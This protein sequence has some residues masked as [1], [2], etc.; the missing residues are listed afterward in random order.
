MKNQKASYPLGSPLARI[1]GFICAIAYFASPAIAQQPDGQT[2]S[3]KNY[4]PSAVSEL[5]PLQ[6]T[7]PAL[8]PQPQ[9]A[10][11][12]LPPVPK[13]FVTPSQF[14]PRAKTD[15]SIQSLQ[16]IFSRTENGQV[17]SRKINRSKIV[18]SNSQPPTARNAHLN[19]LEPIKPANVVLSDSPQ[20]TFRDQAHLDAKTETVATKNPNNRLTPLISIPNVAADVSAEPTKVQPPQARVARAMPAMKPAAV[21]R[22]LPQ[23]NIAKPRLADPNLYLADPRRNSASNGGWANL[24]DQENDSLA[25]DLESNSDIESKEDI[26]SKSRSIQKRLANDQQDQDSLLLALPT[27]N[28]HDPIPRNSMQRATYNRNVADPNLTFAANAYVGSEFR[29]GYQPVTKTWQSPNMVHRPLYFQEENLERYGNGR[30]SLQPIYS[31]VHFFS[32]VAFLPYK[33]GA[34]SPT[35]CVY[36]MGYFR[37]GDCNPAHKKPWNPSRKGLLHQTFATGVVFFG[38]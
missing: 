12:P 5:N 24:Q 31:G 25:D 8:V 23:M 4:Q 18:I 34:Q 35:D 11:R 10:L 22:R 6:S 26:Q 13:N 38:L 17:S 36:T 37:P 19:P 33:T 2:S 27:S 16:P 3:R 29:Q 9:R 15:L 1:F 28:L 32:T 21:A 7:T 14:L 30:G 20:F